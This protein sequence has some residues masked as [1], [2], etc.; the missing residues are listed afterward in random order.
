MPSGDWP[1]RA[2]TR[3]HG[4]VEPR[5]VEPPVAHGVDQPGVEHV[6][7]V[8]LVHEHRVGAGRHR[9]RRGLVE[10]EAGVHRAH[11]ER[12]GDG[13]AVEAEVAQQLVGARLEAGGRSTPDV[14]GR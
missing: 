4:L 11:A 1:R 2:R 9:H 7:L 12:V 10:P 6:D 13:D 14:R 5:L 3:P 8:A